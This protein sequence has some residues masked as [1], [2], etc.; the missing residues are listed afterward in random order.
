MENHFSCCK[1]SQDVPADSK[2][3]VEYGV[4]WGSLLSSA[5]LTRMQSWFGPTMRQDTYKS[6][7]VR[8]C[9]VAQPCATLRDPVDS[10]LPGSSV[11]EIFLCKNTAVSYHFPPPGDLLDLGIRPGSPVSPSLHEDSLSTKPWGKPTGED[12]A[13][14]VT[15]QG[16]VTNFTYCCF[17]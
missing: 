10:S 14:S 2:L 13:L 1:S 11:H 17:S 8:M 15:S 16:E 6:V 5:S 7:Q 3:S 4:F 9:L 12:N